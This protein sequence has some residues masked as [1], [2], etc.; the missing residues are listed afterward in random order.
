MSFRL[1]PLKQTAT[2][3]RLGVRVDAARNPALAALLKAVEVDYVEIDARSAGAP[4][5]TVSASALLARALG[6]PLVVAMAELDR[7]T[8]GPYLDGGAGGLHLPAVASVMAAEAVVAATRYGPLGSRSTFEPGPQNDYADDPQDLG[9]L[10][11]N[12][13]VGVELS[14]VLAPVE[15]AAI[16]ALDGIDAISPSDDGETGEAW[17]SGLSKVA[18][19]AA[20]AGKLAFARVTRLDDIEPALRAGATMITFSDEATVLHDGFARAVTFCQDRL[21]ERVFA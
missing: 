4:A 17:L 3:P 8:F 18:A 11:R 13:Y 10:N 19:I 21:R 16:A 6:L 2:R 9:W 14:T 5:E 1:N 7:E 15:I 12:L 20:G